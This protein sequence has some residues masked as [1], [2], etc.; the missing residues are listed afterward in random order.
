MAIGKGVSMAT[1]L[2][3]GLLGLAAIVGLSV[4]L[5]IEGRTSSLRDRELDDL[6]SQIK[7]VEDITEDINVRPPNGFIN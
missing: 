3:S 1:A 7:T 5:G 4:G 2:T 6:K